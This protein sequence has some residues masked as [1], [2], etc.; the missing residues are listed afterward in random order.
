LPRVKVEK[1]VQPLSIPLARSYRRLFDEDT[2]RVEPAAKKRA[3][4]EPRRGGRV[5]RESAKAKEAREDA[6]PKRRRQ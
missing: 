2:Q 5:R 4:V 3:K 1:L 6:S